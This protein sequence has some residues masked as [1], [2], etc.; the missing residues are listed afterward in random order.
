MKILYKYSIFDVILS[1][2]GTWFIALYSTGYTNL[3]Y[4]KFDLSSLLLN[5]DAGNSEGNLL[6][7]SCRLTYYIVA[8]DK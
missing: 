5:V 2:I 1:D 4:K 8:T 6:N 3:K 7:I